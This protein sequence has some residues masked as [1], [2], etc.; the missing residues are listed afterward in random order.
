MTISI[1][2]FLNINKNLLLVAGSP[3]Q[4]SMLMDLSAQSQSHIGFISDGF[5]L[6]SNLDV[7][8]NI[9]LGPMFHKNMSMRQ[10]R[11][12]I[13]SAIQALGMMKQMHRRKEMLGRGELLRAYLLRSLACD[14]SIV[15]MNTPSL[16]DLDIIQDALERLAYKM[17][18][19]VCC[20]EMN[21]GL[22][23]NYDLMK[24]KLTEQ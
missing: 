2:K 14:N 18:L 6:L 17:R 7:L 11:E 5:P 3:G 21:T 4:L 10:A 23:E 16:Y 19:W 8:G 20:L 12:K 22:Y 9:V 24:I 13:D 1:S 15:L